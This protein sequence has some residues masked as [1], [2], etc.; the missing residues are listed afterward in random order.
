MGERAGG[1]QSCDSLTYYVQTSVLILNGSKK[2]TPNSREHCV[3]VRRRWYPCTG[4]TGSLY[5]F[6]LHFRDCRSIVS[7]HSAIPFHYFPKKEEKGNPSV[8]Y[9]YRY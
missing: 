1:S 9:Y 5:I 6:V 4:E 3:D 8:Q 2:D 7:C